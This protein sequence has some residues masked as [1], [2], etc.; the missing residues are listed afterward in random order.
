MRDPQTEST[1]ASA[2]Q[3]QHIAGLEIHAPITPAFS[4]ILSEEALTFVATLVREFGA[5]R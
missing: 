3:P 2:V 1:P 4:E 5:R